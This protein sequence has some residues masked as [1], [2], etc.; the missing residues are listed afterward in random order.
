MSEF[1]TN[2]VM[3]AWCK[4]SSMCLLGDC[5]LNFFASFSGAK[6]IS[7]GPQYLFDVNIYRRFN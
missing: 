6:L 5:N 1:S 7:V 2:E 3:D 4:V